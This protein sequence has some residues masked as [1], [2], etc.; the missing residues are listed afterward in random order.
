MEPSILLAQLRALLER[1][2]DFEKFSPTS[3]DHMV[4]LGQAHALV[5]RWS[6]M[7]AISLKTSSEFLASSMMKASSLASIFGTLHRAVADLELLVPANV[8]VAFGAGDV[9]DFF[10][11]L[12]KVVASAEK[13]LFIVDPYLDPTVFDHYLSSR[14]ADVQ[15][16][17]LLNRNASKIVPA[18]QKYVAQ[19]GA[20]LQ[21]RE[22]KALHDRV[23]FVDDQVCWLLGQSVKDAAKAK[24][25]YLV[26]LPPDVVPEKLM[27]YEAIWE[28]AAAL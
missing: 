23:V 24:P 4:W 28:S 26:Q 18:S 21:V 25:T 11:A 7:E 22:S 20:V 3:R 12:N 14:Q 17:L 10:K 13:S 1:A 9:Y 5:M 2:P 15:V 16:R 19:Y 6:K 8:E 27:H